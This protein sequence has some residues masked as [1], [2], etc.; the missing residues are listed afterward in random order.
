M[1]NAAADWMDRAVSSFLAVTL[2]EEPSKKATSTTHVDIEPNRP[3]SL[4]ACL[5]SQEEVLAVL[6]PFATS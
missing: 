1:A 2:M 3:L 6:V 4:N 5:T